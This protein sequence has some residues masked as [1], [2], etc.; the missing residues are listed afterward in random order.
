MTF[1]RPQKRTWRTML[2]AWF[3]YIEGRRGGRKI[4]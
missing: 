3:W 2:N 1:R 4:A